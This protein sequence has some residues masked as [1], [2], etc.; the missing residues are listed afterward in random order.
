[1]NSL[2]TIGDLEREADIR[3]SAIRYYE[4]IGLLPNPK[5]V[6]GQ[7]RY[8]SQVLDQIKFIKIAHS[9]GFNNQEVI[10]LLEGFD[11]QTAPSD[12][13]KQMAS[14]KRVELEEKKNQINAMLDILNSGLQCKCLTWTECFAKVKPN[15][16][17]D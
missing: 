14:T 15:G 7:R 16:K 1:M 2:L 11:Q 10:I 9:A 13:W 5:R 8:T 4:S 3:A 12:R 6:N 17:C